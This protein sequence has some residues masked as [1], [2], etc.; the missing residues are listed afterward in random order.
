[1]QYK[2]AEAQVPTTIPTSKGR[3]SISV[4]LDDIKYLLALGFTKSKI[5]EVLGISRKT[6]YNKIA[7][8]PNTD[9]F[10]K[11]SEVTE[12]QLDVIVRS[13]KREYPNDGEVMVAGHLLRLGYRVQR[14]K[15]RAS[16]HRIDPE[17][18]AERRSIAIRQRACHVSAPNEVWHIDGHHKLIKWRLVIHGGIDGYS[19]LITFLRC[20]S[21]NRSD[22][23]LAAFR[24]AVEMY[25]LPTKVRSDHGGENIGV[26]RLMIEEHESDECI[27]VGSSTHNV[28]I[29]R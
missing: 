5:A 10:C 28:R 21:N 24:S 6:L 29:T 11:Y 25:G 23:V 15:L 4:E 20:S 2:M 17:G 7:A 26:W 9:E 18:T 27:I 14:S 3:P 13:V 16:I 19:R 12:A 8:C 1:M 22:T